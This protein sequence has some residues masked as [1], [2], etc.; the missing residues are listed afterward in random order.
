[1]RFLPTFSPIATTDDLKLKLCGYEQQPAAK[2]LNR[3]QAGIAFPPTLGI[4]FSC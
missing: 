2:S 1:M 3:G 4:F